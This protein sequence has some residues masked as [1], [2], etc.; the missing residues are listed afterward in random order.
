MRILQIPKNEIQNFRRYR[1]GLLRQH[2]V[3]QLVF[4]LAVLL[5]PKVPARGGKIYFEDVSFVSTKPLFPTQPVQ[6]P[7]VG[8]PHLTKFLTLSFQ[9]CA[10]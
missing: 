8:A 2:F 7:Q 1:K 5:L 6:Q 9:A 4:R 10:S 3:P